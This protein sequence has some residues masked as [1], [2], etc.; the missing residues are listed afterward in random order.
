MDLSIF[1]DLTGMSDLICKLELDYDDVV[2]TFASPSYETVLGYKSSE[3]LG[4]LR[5]TP[6]QHAMLR[7]HAA[8]EDIIRRVIRG[9]KRFHHLCLTLYT[10][11]GRPYTAYMTLTVRSHCVYLV[12]H[13]TLASTVQREAVLCSDR[14]QVCDD[15]ANGPTP[16]KIRRASVACERAIVESRIH[17]QNY[18][19]TLEVCDL[20]A[21]AQEAGLDVEGGGAS[22]V[23]VRTDPTI[24]DL[25]LYLVAT[26]TDERR[27]TVVDAR[28]VRF[29]VACTAP[30][31]VVF[32]RKHTT[33]D[34]FLANNH[35]S[36]NLRP[37]HNLHVVTRCAAVGNA[38]LAV[39]IDDAVFT[40][41]VVFDPA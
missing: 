24:A 38:T 1:D 20:R 37:T 25:V 26:Y 19:P 2:C 28:S 18:V 34:L 27:V 30:R 29:R 14:V 3:L 33:D 21:L 13:R 23:H 31:K 9:D 6:A 11:E 39:S 16:P 7:G 5:S 15:L 12:S 10:A 41:D 32:C 35:T 36:L 4:P 40:C 17:T 8:F 22:P